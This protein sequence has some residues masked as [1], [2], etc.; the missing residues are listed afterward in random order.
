MGAVA[1]LDKD[2]TA[3]RYCCNDPTSNENSA[4]KR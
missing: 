2:W 4:P 3:R 1:A